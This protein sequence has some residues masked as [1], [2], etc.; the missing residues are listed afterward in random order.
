MIKK[1][2]R[3]NIPATSETAEA[4]SAQPVTPTVAEASAPK[5]PRRKKAASAAETAGEA[6]RT[7]SSS[8]ISQAA[9][10]PVDI[11]TQAVRA[12]AHA[13]YLKEGGRAFDNWI[14]AER[15][16]RAEPAR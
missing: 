9:S 1:T 12:R 14:R 16:L 13:L 6:P 7:A 4:P 5:A 15:E 8:E 11:D 3:K 10:R 2:S